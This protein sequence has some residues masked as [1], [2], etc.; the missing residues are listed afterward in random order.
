MSLLCV[1]GS[2]ALSNHVTN[3]VKMVSESG[4]FHSQKNYFLCSVADFL[5]ALIIHRVVQFSDGLYCC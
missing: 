3:T 4:K 5:L 1:K 2:R